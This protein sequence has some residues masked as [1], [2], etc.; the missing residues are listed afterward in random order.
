MIYMIVL[1]F[2]KRLYQIQKRMQHINRRGE[3][4]FALTEF[5]LQ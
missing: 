1:N 3:R 4:P 2:C 5:Y